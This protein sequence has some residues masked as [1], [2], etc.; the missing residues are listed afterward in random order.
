VGSLPSWI[1]QSLC[2]MYGLPSYD[3]LVRNRR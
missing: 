2:R 3:D 1:D